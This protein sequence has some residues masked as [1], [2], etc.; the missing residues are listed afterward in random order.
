LSQMQYPDPGLQLLLNSAPRK[1]PSLTWL[2]AS[3]VRKH[4]IGYDDIPN[5]LHVKNR[6][7]FN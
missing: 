3:I 1:V 7:G 6:Q 5:D 2:A 4:N